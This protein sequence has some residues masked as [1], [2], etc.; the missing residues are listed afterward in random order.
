[1]LS[2]TSERL[3]ELADVKDRATAGTDPAATERQHAKGKLTARER[4]DLLLDPGSFREIEPLR[5]HRAAGFGLESKRPYTDGVVTGWGTVYDRTVFVYA[6]DFRIYGG[7]L[8]EAH[9]TKIHK[10]M[11]MAEAAGAPLVSLNDGAGARIQEGVTALAGYGGIFQRNVRCSGVIP[12]ISVMV[13]PCAGGAAY[14]PA[15]T[16]FVFAVR[17]ISQMFITGPDVVHA[18]TGEQVT[19]NGLGGADVHA[20]SSGVAHFAYDN[21]QECLE[22]VRYLIS[23]LPSNNRELPPPDTTAD[24]ADRL[25]DRLLDLVPTNPNQA[26]DIRE[27]IA[28]VVDDGDYLEVHEGWAPNIVC[29]LTRV[30]G[31][32]VG[33]VANQP[34]AMAGALDIRASEK[35]ARF[36][37]FCD[38]FNIPLVTLVDVPGFLPGVDQEHDGI[39]RHGAKLLYAY[40][41]ATVPRISVVLRKAYGGAYI[42]MDSR[43]IGA[44]LA[45]A[46]PTNEI[47]VM[48]ADGAA[49][50]IFRKEIAA[51]QDAEAVR[52]QKIKE[53]RTELMH[54]Y[55]AAERGL[56]DDIID[57]RQTRAALIDGLAMLRAKHASL[58]A[59]KHGNPP[60]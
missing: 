1:M 23:L 4:I 25:T 44:D 53:Y 5:R 20:T 13:G 12:Q 2:T 35:G 39:I 17:E 43:S 48:G 37:Q 57:P 56:I 58:P 19:H 15:L 46:W 49:N 27:V 10:I 42:V 45:L 36:V 29:A 18:V 24:P 60:Q 54:P 38:A 55:Y 33:V 21:E 50:V 51:A 34:S 40:C 47:A 8:G 11:D 16:D 14:S 26:Y 28:E 3:A 59:R 22:D 6:H 7:S 41:N 30:G 31:H 52:H 9:A 32:V